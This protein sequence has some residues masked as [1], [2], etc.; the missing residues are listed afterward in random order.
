MGRG[1]GLASG[2]GARKAAAV[3][4]PRGGPS[5]WPFTI[6]GCGAA[7]GGAFWCWMVL[8]SARLGLG[9]GACEVPSPLARTSMLD[10]R[11]ETAALV[12]RMLLRLVPHGDKALS[13]KSLCSN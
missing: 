2:L 8:L 5:G 10:A 1:L 12:H 3:V 9:A 13:V 4:S 7:G 6:G 11:G